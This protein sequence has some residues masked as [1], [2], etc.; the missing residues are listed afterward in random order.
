MSRKRRQS[1]RHMDG[2]ATSISPN[3][4]SVSPRRVLE[5]EVQ[6]EVAQLDHRCAARATLAEYLRKANSVLESVWGFLGA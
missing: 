2:I 3:S 6:M 4:F 5:S 1:R